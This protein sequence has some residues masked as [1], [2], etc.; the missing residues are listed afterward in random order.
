MPPPRRGRSQPW[1]NGS[2]APRS[3][4]LD[5][6]RCA[7]SLWVD[8]T[9]PGRNTLEM[10]VD[11]QHDW[12]QVNVHRQKLKRS[13]RL[14][15]RGK[16]ARSGGCQPAGRLAGV[17]LQGAMCHVGMIQS[18]P[19]AAPLLSSSPPFPTR[20]LLS[21]SQIPAVA[22]LRASDS[23]RFGWSLWVCF[24]GFPVDQSMQRSGSPIKVRA[25]PEMTEESL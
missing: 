22:F 4:A 2:M 8:G 18:T 7:R 13:S 14:M 9:T 15:E 3:V 12:G 16:G 11:S 25:P 6:W 17:T 23:T 10:S 21:S 19:D 1:R 20:A 5:R 24:Q